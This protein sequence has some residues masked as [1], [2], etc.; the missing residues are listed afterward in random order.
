MS[1]SKISVIIPLY[2]AEK[3]IRQTLISVLASKFKDCEVIVVDDCSTDNSVA[4]VEKML[5]HFD[6]RLKI[7]ST[8][9]NSGGAGVPRNIGI[10]NSAG[11]Y[12]CFLDADDFLLPTALGELFDVAEKFQA[13]VL[14]T[15]K[16]L[17][18]NNTGESNFR[19]ENLILRKDEAGECVEV[20][21]PEPV[22]VCEKIRRCIEGRFLWM[23]WGKFYRRE[24]LTENEIYFPDM[25]FTEDLVFCFKCLLLAKNYIRIPNVTNIYRMNQ[26]SVSKK[27]ISSRE[28]VKLWL[29]SVSDGFGLI[30]DFMNAEKNFRDNDDAKYLVTDFLT[31]TYFSFI[32][33]LFQGRTPHE[34]EKIFFDELQNPAL[35]PTGKNL[36]IAH[37]CAERVLT[38]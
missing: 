16:F 35:N 1:E 2:N 22:D 30:A 37:M 28:G 12:I 7:L 5:P 25:K 33:N 24:F 19:R 27:I 17:T 9:K 26:N 29:N 31:A 13:D 18:F 38:R 14:H 36:F 20:P 23:P 32:K 3:F 34:I 6:G 15:E 21:T 10:K 11:K 8:G 4:E